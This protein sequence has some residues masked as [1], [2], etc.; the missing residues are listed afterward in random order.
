MD[1]RSGWSLY[2]RRKFGASGHQQRYRFK[3]DEPL[4]LEGCFPGYTEAIGKRVKVLIE[5][6]NWKASQSADRE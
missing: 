1:E 2:K 6:G 5:S 4:D 3:L